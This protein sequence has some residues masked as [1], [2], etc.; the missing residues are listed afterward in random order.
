MKDLLGK[1]FEE[2]YAEECR[3]RVSERRETARGLPS[4]HRDIIRSAP[5]KGRI[6]GTIGR[7][8]SLPRPP[9]L[10]RTIGHGRFDDTGRVRRR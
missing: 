5:V 7:D 1:W 2:G 3:Y 8:F 9:Q 6:L 4:A 10:L